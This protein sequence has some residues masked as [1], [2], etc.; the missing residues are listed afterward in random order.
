MK[1]TGRSRERKTDVSAPDANDFGPEA[2]GF[3][4]WI[5]CYKRRV[6]PF[7][8][9]APPKLVGS[10]DNESLSD[11]HRHLSIV[12]TVEDDCSHVLAM[13]SMLGMKR[14]P[15]Q[16]LLAYHSDRSLEQ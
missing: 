2:P 12:E 8:Q 11:R 7:D 14:T 3:N 6:W 4:F 13:L 10:S 9:C 1:R 15:T 5:F 16:V